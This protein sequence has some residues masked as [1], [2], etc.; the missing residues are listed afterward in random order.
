MVK[1]ELINELSRR[2]GFTKEDS[3]FFLNAF[4]NTVK[5]SLAHGERVKI[6]DFGSFEVRESSGRVGKNFFDNTPALIRTRNVPLFVPGEG[7][8]EAARRCSDNG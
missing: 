1:K 6:V 4:C 5:D 8:K 7:L 2:T 3:E